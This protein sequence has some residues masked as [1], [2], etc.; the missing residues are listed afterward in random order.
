MFPYPSGAGLHVGHPEGYT[1]TDIIARIQ[2]RCRASTSCTRWAGTRSAC[3]PSRHAMPDQHAPG[4]HRR[5]TQ[6]RHLP[7]PDP[8]ARLLL[9]LGSRGQHDRSRR[10]FRWTQWI[11]LKLYERG[12]AYDGGR[13]GQLVV[14]RSAPCSPT[15]RS[16]TE[17]A[18]RP[19][20]RCERRPMRQWMLKI[21]EYA[22]R[23]LDRPRGCRLARE[24]QGD[25][26]QLDRP[27]RGCRGRVSRSPTAIGDFTVFHH[28]ARHPVWRH[29]HACLRPSTR[30]WRSRS[31]PTAAALRRRRGLRRRGGQPRATSTAPTS[32]RTKTGVFTGA[33][34]IN[35]VN[36]ERIPVW[37]AD[38]VLVTYGTGAIMAVPGH[39]PAR[40]GVRQEFDL[41][42]IRTVEPPDRLATARPTWA[43]GP[44]INSQTADSTGMTSPT[45]RRADHRVARPE[46]GRRH[47]RRS[48]TSSATGC[49]R[50]SATGVSRS[51]WCTPRT[52]R[53]A[54]LPEDWLPVELAGDRRVLGRPTTGARRWRVQA[55]TGCE[56]EL[57]DGRTGDPRD[58]H[59][60]AVGRLLLVLPAL[61]RP[62]QRKRGL[63]ER[64]RGLLDAGR[65]LR[66]RGRARGAPP[67]VRPLL[68]QGALRLRRWSTPRSRSRSSSTRA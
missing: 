50:A 7:P 19:A 23:L 10:Y 42:I 32:P 54:P 34:A 68:A 37:I 51:R 11:F 27:L 28:A 44:A 62:A 36:D 3:R 30:W 64:S 22:E 40:L 61:P 26:A 43:D 17:R 58:Q 24:R 46:R 5:Q 21:T 41:P 2:A 6:H 8:A 33:Y 31:P 56:V 1:A 35:P 67:A 4:G 53:C 38:Y 25:A 47:R 57:P 18:W 65:P 12:L 15:R 13:S 9:R 66:R 29:L 52:A 39:D 59:H 45:P 48:S 63:V 14:R 60:A 55:T 16:R 49:S 20:T